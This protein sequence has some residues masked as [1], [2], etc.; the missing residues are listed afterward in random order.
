MP[1]IPHDDV[2]LPE[3]VQGIRAELRTRAAARSAVAETSLRTQK[4]I[5]ADVDR[6]FSGGTVRQRRG[7]GRRVGGPVMARQPARNLL[8]KIESA[9]GSGSFITLGML[10]T[11]DVTINTNQIDVTSKDSLNDRRDLDT[12]IQ[13]MSTSGRGFFDAGPAW[14][15]V[16]GAD[17][18]T[19]EA[20]FPDFCLRDLRYDALTVEGTL[21]LEAFIAEPY[22]ARIFSPAEFPG[23]FR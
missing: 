17:P 4:A 12:G 15:R 6:I 22:P 19:V 2:V 16:R 18:D 11:S 14:Q 8:L 13:S 5:R 23:L 1:H 7:R 3:E 10:Q 9:E 20:V 21:T